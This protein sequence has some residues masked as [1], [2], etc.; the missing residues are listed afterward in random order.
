MKNLKA[1]TRNY[2]NALR[3]V[4]N[5][6][7]LVM[8]LNLMLCLGKL[9][10]GGS[11]HSVSMVADGFHSLMDA[12][13][14][15]L[16]FGSV[17]IAAQPPDKE[18][19]Y[20]HQKFE[21]FAALGIAVL[22]GV[23]CV[24]I[25]TSAIS[26]VGNPGALPHPNTLSF[27][28]MILTM[29]VNGW[30]SWY[31]GRSGRR[32]QSPILAADSVHTGSDLLS[33]AAVLAALGGAELGWGWVDF[34]A[35]LMVVV[36]VGKATWDILNEAQQVLA[37]HIMLDPAEVVGVVQSVPGVISCRKVRS[38]GMPGNVFVDLHIQVAPRLTML[39]A[40]ALTHQVMEK[41]RKMVPGVKE[42]FVHTEPGKK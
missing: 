13:A 33:S 25:L 15:G 20:G 29:G 37:D 6:L 2:P 21:I 4:G 9:I 8:V 36:I 23:A 22:M 14:N 30:C 1:K 24:E 11:V 16:A 39:K 28:V 3:E 26:H 41:V 27:I 7:I 42:V 5:V 34:A 12:L 32:L 17:W 40:H 10:V 19:P 35:S 31:E 38:R 18:H